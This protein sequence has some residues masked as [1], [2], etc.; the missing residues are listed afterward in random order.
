M[1]TVEMSGR[2]GLTW[3]T[4]LTITSLL[5]GGGALNALAEGHGGGD[6]GGGSGKA[7]A[8]HQQQQPP[9]L[10]K[11]AKQ[12]SE[13]G[14]STNHQAPVHD[15]KQASAQAQGTDDNSNSDH[16]TV[17]RDN[18]GVDDLVTPPALV[19]GEDR[20]G[21]GCG[22]MNHVHTGPPGNPDKTCKSGADDANDNAATTDDDATSSVTAASNDDLSSA[23]TA[24]SDAN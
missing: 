24:D 15:N 14:S 3:V 2:N 17:D 20:P 5:L 12:D 18:S 23:A 19:T 7:N 11:Q 21:L 13:G 1:G 6:H 4:A 22:D 10:V 8:A 9:G 16:S